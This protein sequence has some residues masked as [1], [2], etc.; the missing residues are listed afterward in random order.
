MLPT[1]RALL[2]HLPGI[3][4]VCGRWPA[5]PVC[6][7]CAQ[8]FAGPATRCTVCA[9]RVPEGLSRCGACL[10]RPDPPPVQACSAAVD[11]AYPWDH[12]I[13]R[14]KFRGE[15]GWAAPFAQQMLRAPLARELLGQ[16]N[17]M[18]PVPLTHT[19]LGERGHNQA[20]EL[21]K[22]LR[23]QTGLQTQASPDALVRLVEAHDQHR[24]TREQRLHNL[25]G[26]FAAHP[27]RVTHIRAAHV[28]LVDDVATTGATLH[29]A[30]LALLQAG[31]ARVSALVFA[32]T[33]P[34]D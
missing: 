6:D 28:L 34:P 24:L 18:V 9:A 5:R 31:A 32:R 33:P 11:Y 21:V 10:I 3:C 2:D 12:L 23:R 7:A 27:E 1:W 30:A 26:V 22:A 29:A 14:F 4:Q 13:A 25:R 19:R 17:L 16:G 8:R 20:W 15:P